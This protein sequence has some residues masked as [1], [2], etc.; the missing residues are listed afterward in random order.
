MDPWTFINQKKVSFRSSLG[1]ATKGCN[2]WALILVLKQWCQVLLSGSSNRM[3]LPMTQ[4]YM[5]QSFRILD[6]WAQMA[7]AI[8]CSFQWPK[9][10]FNNFLECWML[11]CKWQQ[12]DAFEGI[13][14]FIFYFLIL[15]LVTRVLSDIG[16]LDF[17]QIYFQLCNRI[18]KRHAKIFV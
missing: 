10:T 14:R 12:I 6:A 15:F 5:Q 17:I 4:S 11:E 8:E 16:D 1:C 9:A 7:W 3:L 18:P 2:T 13:I